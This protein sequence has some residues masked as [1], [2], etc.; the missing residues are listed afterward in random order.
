MSGARTAGPLRPV[1]NLY[2]PGRAIGGGPKRLDRLSDSQEDRPYELF[3]LVPYG[4][5]IG[6]EI[7]GVDLRRPI[8]A[9]LRAELHRA[10][11]EWKVL[12]FRGQELTDAQ[13]LRFARLWGPLEC[14]PFLPTGAQPDIVRFA[15]NDSVRGVENTWHA[16]VTWRERPALG[17]VLRVTQVPP[18]GGD[19]LWA[20]AAAAYDNLPD[21]VRARLDGLTAVHDFGPSIGAFMAPDVLS[22]WQRRYPAVEH[23]VV[24]T[25]PETGRRT[26]F[27]NATYTT[28]IVGL[29]TDESEELLQYLFRQLHLPEYQVRLRWKPHTVAFWDNRATQHYAV[30]DYYPHRR[31]GERAAIEGDRPC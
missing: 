15:K 13:H 4:P 14:N 21:S 22:D 7:R 2:R 18:L 12:F 1:P 26:L 10:F 31:T 25:H 17:A 30:S 29:L 23:P 20:D 3:D 24:R 8:G 27:V 6:A 28:E 19:T 5:L 9:Q 16:D 11:L